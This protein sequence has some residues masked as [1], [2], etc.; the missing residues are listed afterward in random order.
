MFAK[1]VAIPAAALALALA[2]C[3]GDSDAERKRKDAIEQVVLDFAA[4]DGREAFDLLSV[5]GLEKV[6]GLD[7]AQ[8]AY[9]NCVE[10]SDKFEGE[11]VDIDEV[12]LGEGDG[13][14]VEA[15]T[16]D[17]SREYRVRVK[18]ISGEWRITDIAE[19]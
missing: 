5:E 18:R 3:G 6:Y 15:S 14:T 8:P 13:A 4:A 17:D 9:W 11:K 19:V 2:G 1:R 16:Q 10:A 7:D 12:K